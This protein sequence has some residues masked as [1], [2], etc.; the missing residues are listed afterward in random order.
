[1]LFIHHTLLGE[2]WQI[3]DIRT[4]FYL[5]PMVSCGVLCDGGQKC[6]E[7]ACLFSALLADNILHMRRIALIISA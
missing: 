4:R 1:M 3:A 7:N 6:A 5:G 2:S